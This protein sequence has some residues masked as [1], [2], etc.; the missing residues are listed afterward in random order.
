M[1][2]CFRLTPSG[3]N[4]LVGT[5]DF[6]ATCQALFDAHTQPTLLQRWLLGPLGW[7]MSVCEIDLRVGGTYRWAWRR[8]TMGVSGE[9]L[10]V[11]PPVRP[12]NT[13]KFEAVW[14]EGGCV[15]TLEL[16]D[17]GD[18][19]PRFTSTMTFD[20]TEIRNSVMQAGMAA[21][22]KASC[23]RLEILVSGQR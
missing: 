10:E 19:R 9:Y 16:T 20:S 18:G 8:S 15:V 6:D 17:L 4:D 11:T 1:S 7:E 2:R 14:Y 13:E 22:L 5:R 3:P 23:G 21:G 12:V